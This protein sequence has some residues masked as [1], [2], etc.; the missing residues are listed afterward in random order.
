MVADLLRDRQ[1]EKPL[2]GTRPADAADAADTRAT[3]H[4]P[5]LRT[6]AD[7]CGRPAETPLHPQNP[8]TSANPQTHATPSDPH[9]PQVPQPTG[10]ANASDHAELRAR[11]HQLAESENLPPDIVDRLTDAAAPELAELRARL[12]GIAEAHAIPAEI[13]QAIATDAALHW[14]AGMTDFQLARWLNIVGTRE[15]YRRGLLTH[16][17][18][19]PSTA[20]VQP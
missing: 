7:S 16:G 15:L 4:F 2:P 17:W 6:V 8:Q 20:D 9:D 19:I 3:P 13:V 14:C 1:H 11:L 12:L 5:R 10:S 18:A